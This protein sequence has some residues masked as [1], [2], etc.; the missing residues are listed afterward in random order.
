[1]LLVLGCAAVAGA[2]YLG[3]GPKRQTALVVPEGAFLVLR[4]DVSALRRSAALSSLP[5]D[6]IGMWL[7]GA[8][9][10][11]ACGFDPTARV[12]EFLA[13]VPEGGDKGEFAI[14]ARTTVPKDDLMR[15][16]ERLAREGGRDLTT[17]TEGRDTSMTLP[18]QEGELV[19]REGGLLAIGQ[20][21]F[22][23]VLLATLD[24]KLA[25]ASPQSPHVRLAHHLGHASEPSATSTTVVATVVLPRSLRERLK[26]ENAGADATA[27]MGG[28]LGVEA[29]G[30]RLTTG[31]SGGTTEVSARFVCES[32]GA[33]AE[34]D[35]LLQAQR[36][37]LSQQLGLRLAGFG[38]L[39]DSFTTEPNGPALGA[40]ARTRTDDLSRAIAFAADYLSRSAPTPQ[41][42]APPEPAK[43]TPDEV[44]RPRPNARPPATGPVPDTSARAR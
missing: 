32:A 39:V 8:R 38:P 40:T 29:L 44:L 42:D 37:K 3:E 2:A 9:A 22:L 7:N 27:A 34:V 26:A 25:G 35:R 23:S 6:K 24:G 12:G 1:M 28:V 4:G 19:Y 15:C 13:V 5:L 10:S 36:L 16:V 17:K 31:A 21:P 14:V 41:P 43:V 33:C 20:R 11:T 18:K 30:V